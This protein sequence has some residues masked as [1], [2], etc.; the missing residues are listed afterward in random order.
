MR[1]RDGITLI[2]PWNDANWDRQH[3]KFSFGGDVDRRRV[4][5]MVRKSMAQIGLRIRKETLRLL[6]HPSSMWHNRGLI[7]E[8]SGT[9][10]VDE[11]LDD[12]APTKGE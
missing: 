4:R 5:R 9:R 6:L 8:Y 12:E 2:V 7:F 11:V 3:S 10:P 1:Y